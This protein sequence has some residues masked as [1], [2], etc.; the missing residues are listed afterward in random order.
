[1]DSI[2]VLTDA[3]S[4]PL[5]A[6]DRILDGLDPDLLHALPEGRGNSIAWLVW[7]AARQWDAQVAHLAGAAQV[8]EAGGWPTRTGVDRP[9]SE[10][11]FGDTAEEAAALRVSSADALRGYWQAVSDHLAAYLSGLTEASL[12][13][14]IDTSWDPPVTRGVRLISVID[15]AVAHLGQ[16]QYARG[17]LSGWRIGY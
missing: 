6:V 4:R 11:G 5:G 12:S 14:V 9:D 15:D 17:L 8:W 16:A 10:V 13:E 2:A 1:M 7:H 3:A